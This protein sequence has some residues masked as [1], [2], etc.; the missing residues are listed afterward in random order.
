MQKTTDKSLENIAKQTLEKL[1]S[2]GILPYPK[3]Y[4]DVFI[5]LISKNT[6]IDLD[7]IEKHADLFIKDNEDNKLINETI[8]IAKENV[9]VFEK[10]NQNLRKISKDKSVELSELNE[11]EGTIDTSTVR[12]LCESLI[13]DILDELSKT[14]QIVKKM[15]EKL[16]EFEKDANIHPLTKIYNYKIYENRLKSILD[17]GQDRDLD[18]FVAIIDADNFSHIND[19][20]GRVAGDKTLVYLARTLQGILREDT[21]IYHTEGT[22]FILVLNRL[23]QK[24]AKDTMERIVKEIHESKLY[25]KGNNI[26]LTVSV[27]ITKHKKGDTFETINQRAKEAVA[28]AKKS[29]KNC[30]KEVY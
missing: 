5:D 10:S 2:L 3:Y 19:T 22:E 1:E 20:C 18:V 23:I 24:N 7:I 12:K 11:E 17:I 30:Y 27:G 29:G 8:Q 6:D 4:N 16:E 21:K 13:Y 15:Q 25:Y 14:D 26:N 28:L 9:L